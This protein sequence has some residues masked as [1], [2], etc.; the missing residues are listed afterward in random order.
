MKRVNYIAF[1]LISMV[2]LSGCIN[3]DIFQKLKRNGNYDLLYRINLPK[4]FIGTMDQ[5]KDSFTVDPSLLGKVMVY[6]SQNSLSMRFKD[7]NFEKN[8]KIFDKI[9]PAKIN[10]EN[11]IDANLSITDPSNFAYK[12]EFKFPL[13]IYTFS[14]KQG[15]K[16]TPI[17]DDINWNSHILDNSNLL[18]NESNTKTKVSFESIF[19]RSGVEGLLF[20]KPNLNNTRWM[21]QRQDF[22]DNFSF[23]NDGGKYILFSISPN[24]PVFCRI[25]S[26]LFFDFMF[27]DNISHFSS[28]FS[29]E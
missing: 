21:K 29:K 28:E 3:I 27:F 20:I 8:K 11:I 12:K 7:L 14:F 5:V 18:T 17:K 19:A 15:K 9:S 26:N 4:E 23:S 24:D 6:T 13:Y 2:F 16:D 22:V 25:E 10:Q 1:F